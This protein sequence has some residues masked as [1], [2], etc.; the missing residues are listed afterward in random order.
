MAF[1]RRLAAA[2]TLAVTSAGCDSAERRPCIADDCTCASD[3]ECVIEDCY[4]ATLPHP[5]GV[6][7]CTGGET[8]DCVH[9]CDCTN[10]YP[11]PARVRD[12]LTTG[13]GESCESYYCEGSGACDCFDDTVTY[14]PRCE[15]GR[16]VGVP[17]SD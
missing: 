14:E 12:E 7:D 17:K 3:D 6:S 15:W 16:C 1:V 4:F 2:L 5:E 8:C 13:L 9:L 10:G 11:L